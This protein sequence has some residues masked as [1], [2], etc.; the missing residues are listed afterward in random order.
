MKAQYKGQSIKIREEG[1]GYTV[2]F[3]MGAHTDTV[4]GF[5]NP[6]DALAYAKVRIALAGCKPAKKITRAQAWA[7]EEDDW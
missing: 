5:A 1:S 6:Y 4:I 2:E 3:G 7:L